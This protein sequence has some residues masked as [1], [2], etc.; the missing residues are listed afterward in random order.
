MTTSCTDDAS[1]T[2]GDAS[3]PLNG[4]ARFLLFVAVGLAGMLFGYGFMGMDD[5]NWIQIAVE[6]AVP[7]LLLVIVGFVVIDG[8][9]S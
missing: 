4:T 8:S 2:T 6:V 3:T 1:T 7:A 5:S 9:G